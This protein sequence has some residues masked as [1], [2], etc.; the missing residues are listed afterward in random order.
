[1]ISFDTMMGILNGAAEM[2]EVN[3]AV[4]EILDI[5]WQLL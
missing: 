2:Q 4:L 1:M 3:T 5:V